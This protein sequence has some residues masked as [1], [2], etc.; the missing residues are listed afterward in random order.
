MATIMTT[1][2]I[3]KAIKENKFVA[4]LFWKSNFWGNNFTL[5]TYTILKTR[6]HKRPLAFVEIYHN[7]NKN[8]LNLSITYAKTKECVYCK[9]IQDFESNLMKINK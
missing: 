3:R 6:K 7:V 9:T 5:T 2:D 4:N 8:V 1:T